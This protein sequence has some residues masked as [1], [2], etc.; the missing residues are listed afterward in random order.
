MD[1][2][3][4]VRRVEQIRHLYEVEGDIEAAH[5]DQDRLYEDVLTTV[6]MCAPDWLAE[7]AGIALS[8]REIVQEKWYA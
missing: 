6:R 3:I 2:Q 5:L 8:T 1:K 4:A 7:I